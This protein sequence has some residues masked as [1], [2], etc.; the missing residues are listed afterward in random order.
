MQSIAGLVVMSGFMYARESGIWRWSFASGDVF[1]SMV[2]LSAGLVVLATEL[3]KNVQVYFGFQQYVFVP[4]DSRGMSK[5][6]W[7]I[8]AVLSV[9]FIWD[10][11]VPH[12]DEPLDFGL[13]AFYAKDAR[14]VP[15]SQNTAIALMGLAAPSG[16][17]FIAYGKE[18]TALS[19]L[20]TDAADQFIEANGELKFKGNLEDIDC[21]FSI[22]EVATKACRN[23]S[24]LKTIR[25][26]NA[27]LLERY[28]IAASLTAYQKDGFGRNGKLFIT[29]NKFIAA[30]IISDVSE[31]KDEVA[32]Q[33]WRENHQF[34]SRLAAA[35]SS[36]VEKLILN[37]AEGVSLVAAENLLFAAPRVT[38]THADE[39]QK[40][41]AAPDIARWSI[42]GTLRAEFW[43]LEPILEGAAEGWVHP[44]YLRNRQYRSAMDILTAIRSSP[45]TLIENLKAIET[46]YSSEQWQFVD[47]V[48]HTRNVEYGNNIIA[49]G[50]RFAS[51]VGAWQAKLGSM[52]LLALNALLAH[53]KVADGE[54]EQFLRRAG[55]ELQNPAN[56]QPAQWNAEY[57]TIFFCTH[58]PSRLIQSRLPGGRWFE[59]S[60]KLC[61]KALDETSRQ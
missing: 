50:A 22:D 9:F 60:E 24:R 26:E 51:I 38:I 1:F 35:E 31:G 48:L 34:L 13:N 4:K 29:I 11:L 30:E 6:A 18:L 14:V 19:K 2:I 52:R 55:P 39:L 49:S 32:F 59:S 44:N 56:G 43:L 53:G 54:I 37:V 17:D 40:L 15:T 5:L 58:E 20:P 21:W 33:K 36:L 42:K 28:R 16:R 8:P 10:L 41:L 27:E 7:L 57:R 12:Y 23:P 61:G 3:T 47:Y 25:A 45:K 46:K